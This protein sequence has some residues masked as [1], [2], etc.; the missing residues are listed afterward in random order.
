MFEE[1]VEIRSERNGRQG[2]GFALGLSLL[3]YY[4]PLDCGAV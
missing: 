2:L 1:A 4:V 3:T